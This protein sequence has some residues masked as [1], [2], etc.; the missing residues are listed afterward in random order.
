MVSYRKKTNSIVLEESQYG[1]E[2]KS[3]ETLDPGQAYSIKKPF[4]ALKPGKYTLKAT[5][6]YAEGK[7][8]ILETSTLVEPK[9]EAE[10]NIG[11]IM[12]GYTLTRLSLKF[13]LD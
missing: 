5:L 8:I 7:P 12:I 1:N 10:F 3:L 2:K 4:T 13:K 6:T 9:I 11:C